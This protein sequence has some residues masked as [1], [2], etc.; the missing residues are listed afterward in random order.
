L[1]EALGKIVETIKAENLINEL[2]E[3]MEEGA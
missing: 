3:E 2:E 1:Y